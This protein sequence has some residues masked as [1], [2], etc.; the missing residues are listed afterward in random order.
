MELNFCGYLHCV[1]FGLLA[2]WRPANLTTSV[3]YCTDCDFTCNIQSLQLDCLF[4]MILCRTITLIELVTRN[5][6][7]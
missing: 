4:V 3:I 7:L 5:V 1:Y 2:G 6:Y